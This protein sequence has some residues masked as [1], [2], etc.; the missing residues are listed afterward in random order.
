MHLK[1][2]IWCKQRHQIGKGQIPAINMGYKQVCGCYINE[3]EIMD[4]GCRY[5]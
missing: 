4:V 2:I 3:V 1:V 5:G